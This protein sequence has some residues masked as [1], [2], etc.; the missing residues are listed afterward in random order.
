MSPTVRRGLT[1]VVVELCLLAAT[2]LFLG[3]TPLSERTILVGDSP[4]YYDPAFRAMAPQVFDSRPS[5]FLMDVDNN[6]HNY[7][8]RRFVQS[9]L[10]QNTLPLWNPYVAMGVP[11]V[12]LMSGAFDPIVLAA[13]VVAPPERLTNAVVFIALPVA[14]TG[15]FLLLS[16]FSLPRTTRLFG[17]IAF[18]FCGGM[19]VWLGRMNFLALVWL[20]WLFAAGEALLRRP[21]APRCGGL[22]VA[23]ALVTLPAHLQTTFHCL[24][25]LSLYLGSRLLQ[26]VTPT[27]RRRWAVGA[28]VGGV[29]LGLAI[30]AVQ[31]LPALDLLHQP[32]LPMVSRAN[33]EAAAT[34]GDALHH[35]LRGDPRTMRSIL[36]TA[37]TAV[38]PNLFGSPRHASSWWPASNYAETNL[39]IG[40]LP[41]FFALYGVAHLRRLKEIRGWALVAVAAFGVAYALPVA[42]LV[43]YLPAFNQINNARLRLLYQFA[44]IVCAVF[45]LEQYLAD[46][47]EGGRG[48]RTAAFALFA[49]AVLALP[50]LL[51]AVLSHL[52]IGQ[53]ALTHTARPTIDALLKTEELRNLALLAA[54]GVAVTAWWHH[55]LPTRWLRGVMGLLLFADLFWCLHDFNPT[56]PSEYVYPTPPAVAFLQQDQGTFR[57][58]S[59]S[60]ATILPPNTKLLYGLYDVDLF[61][62][63]G[64][65]RYIRF[66]RIFNPPTSDAFRNFIF[67]QPGQVQRLIDLMNIKYLVSQPWASPRDWMR[68]PFRS[69][70]NYQLVYD[71]GVRIYKNQSVLPRTFLVHTS[72]HFDAPESALAALFDPTFEPQRVVYLEDSTAPEL[73]SGEAAPEGEAAVVRHLGINEMT[74]E[75]TVTAPAYLLLSEAY[76]PGWRATVDG[77]AAPVY[78]A[79][80]LFRA[81]HLTPGHHTVRLAFHSPAFDH[82]WQI[83]AAALAI[84]LLLLATALRRSSQAQP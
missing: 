64:I 4:Y 36:P 52:A 18:A 41:L 16:L 50:P 7:P 25:A 45:G 10:H 68:D 75:A 33:V 20:P 54:A 61:C 72:R 48:K 28:A 32:D 17:A 76:Y 26:G 77:E 14:A 21:T 58:S 47:K 2:F 83:S 59:T 13:A 69:D 6:L 78:A 49:G 62:V 81:I 55:R 66:Q 30:G 84:S 22:A 15:M 82:G 27:R 79:D 24:A 39:Y 80:Y 11:F 8:F 57:V 19:V 43:N 34:L 42:N 37:L 74:V 29:G 35:G 38:A 40:L 1:L 53:A 23:V 5:N 63:L 70:A 44:A 67:T 46:R 31:L 12:G 60:G 71:Q 56:L 3:I 51:V 73:A 65:D 9:C